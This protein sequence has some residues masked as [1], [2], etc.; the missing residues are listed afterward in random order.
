LCLEGDVA[1]FKTVVSI[2]LGCGAPLIQ[3]DISNCFLRRVLD[4]R[5][6]VALPGAPQPQ[7]GSGTEYARLVC[8]AQLRRLPQRLLDNDGGRNVAILWR[9][10][11]SGAT[12][13]PRE[14][15]DV[16]RSA[17]RGRTK[18]GLWTRTD[19]LSSLLV[20]SAL[21]GHPGAVTALQQWSS[22]SAPAGDTDETS[23]KV[24][25]WRLRKLA[26]RYP[27]AYPHLLADAAIE[28][29]GQF[30]LGALDSPEARGTPIPADVVPRIV[31][32]A[33]SLLASNTPETKRIAFEQLRKAGAAYTV[34]ASLLVDE[35][36]RTRHQGTLNSIIRLIGATLDH[37]ASRLS[38]PADY[39]GLVEALQQ[40]RARGTPPDHEPAAAPKHSNP[41]R[42]PRSELA[43]GAA[44][45]LRQLHCRCGPVADPGARAA[46]THVVR[47][48]VLQANNR[49]HL[50][51]LGYF[52]SRLSAVD[53]SA[54]AATLLEVSHII[55]TWPGSE[56]TWKRR[57]AH[58]W[59][60]GIA[61]VLAAHDWSDWKTTIADL[62]SAE[63]NIFT[64]AM[65][66]SIQSRGTAAEK[67]LDTVINEV[68]DTG[69]RL[70]AAFTNAVARRQR[71][72][73]SQSAWPNVLQLC[74]TVLQPPP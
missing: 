43:E 2:L 17:T 12:M 65:E 71:V 29:D 22:R 14:V 1:D 19:G 5:H 55:A 18:S 73:G 49:E 11:L 10:A 48:T 54:A 16:T 51:P 35:L 4:G 62:A 53:P 69:G 41:K 47:S 23:R 60:A 70:R 38:A 50:A 45:C 58:R 44:R 42:G 33:P 40:L 72:I 13:P 28:T 34:D 9:D 63:P 24:I 36:K 68:D 67:Y 7:S 21:G 8:A 27:T 74:Q 66:V 56:T 26:H 46:T 64:Q 37:D 15:A 32:I 59:R 39:A 3:T 57:R 52:M 30:L 25:A 61:D 20:P 6:G 31:A